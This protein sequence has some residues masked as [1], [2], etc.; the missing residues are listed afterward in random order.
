VLRR[1]RPLLA[2]TLGALAVMPVIKS[3][4]A[5]ATGIGVGATASWADDVSAMT[6][7]VRP[8]VR[9]LGSASASVVSLRRTNIFGV[10]CTGTTYTSQFKADPELTSA[11][12]GHVDI[13]CYNI[14]TGAHE[15]LYDIA[16]D[17][18]RTG[19]PVPS[20][21]GV[22]G[23]AAPAEATFTSGCCR[24]PS[25]G[26]GTSSATIDFGVFPLPLPTS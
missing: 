22:V 9:R 26:S 20:V 17:W 13:D 8:D 23:I 7:A 4:P 1:N 16:T 18:V 12:L 24:Y 25:L 19:N 5:R 21:L 14:D 15:G 11:S 10:T 3:T 2:I 6:I